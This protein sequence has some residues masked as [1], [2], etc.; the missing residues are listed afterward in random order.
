M[1]KRRQT[2]LVKFLRAYLAW[3]DGGAP[4]RAPFWRGW[5]LCGNAE[6]YSFK[7]GVC[8]ASLS[9]ALARAFEQ[10]GLNK[11]YPFGYRRYWGRPHEARPA[12]GE[13]G[14]TANLD[15]QTTGNSYRDPVRLAWVRWYL[16]R[17]DAGLV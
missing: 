10:D 13:W 8:A 14:S 11:S 9:F 2:T 15:G 16:A 6:I 17:F 3:V 12:A 7:K 1:A 4:S 5:G